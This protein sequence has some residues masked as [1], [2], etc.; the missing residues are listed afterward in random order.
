MRYGT[1]TVSL[2]IAKYVPDWVDIARAVLQRLVF[3]RSVFEAQKFEG[4]EALGSCFH[5]R[6]QDG[7]LGKEWSEI[8][9]IPYIARII[10]SGCYAPD[11]E[12]DLF[13]ES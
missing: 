10:V 11:F 8:I 13:R 4:L 3:R 1:N 9:M 12:T 5:A 6:L 2:E 7:R